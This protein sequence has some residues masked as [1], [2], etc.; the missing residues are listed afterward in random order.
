MTLL[1][2]RIYRYVK[3]RLSELCGSDVIILDNQGVLY[4]SY[5]VKTRLSEVC[6][7]HVIISYNQG[8]WINED[9]FFA[10]NLQYVVSLQ[11]VE[12]KQVWMMQR[13]D[14]YGA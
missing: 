7:I 8:V 6:G 12:L 2:F 11:V 10:H 3:P 1:G 14:N 9:I 5:A 4:Y 13:T